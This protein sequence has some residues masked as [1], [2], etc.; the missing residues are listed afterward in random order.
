VL[1]ALQL[2]LL[3]EAEAEAEVPAKSIWQ[4]QGRICLKQ[5]CLTEELSHDSLHDSTHKELNPSGCM[6]MMG[7]LH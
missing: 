5:S 6:G 2:L 4:G 3:A 7:E 1:L